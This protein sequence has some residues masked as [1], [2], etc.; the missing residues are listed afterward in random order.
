MV[1]HT[2]NIVWELLLQVCTK[3]FSVFLNLVKFSW[4]PSTLP[5]KCCWKR[6]KLLLVC[7]KI[8]SFLPPHSDELFNGSLIQQVPCCVSSSLVTTAFAEHKSSGV[9]LVLVNGKRPGLMMCSHSFIFRSFLMEEI[10]NQRCS[11][12][13]TYPITGALWKCDMD[14]SNT[15]SFSQK[16][17]WVCRH[18][19]FGKHQ[20]PDRLALWLLLVG[21]DLLLTTCLLTINTPWCSCVWHP[22]NKPWFIWPHTIPPPLCGLENSI[23][24]ILKWN[25]FKSVTTKGADI[26]KERYLCESDFTLPE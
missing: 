7:T 3:R 17:I 14:Q 25:P 15:P 4:L 12:K 13:P 20:E 26:F 22:Y 5:T 1:E 8:G 18:C 10:E 24:G 2:G 9:S 21:S 23:R 6:R 11:T 19:T 16:R